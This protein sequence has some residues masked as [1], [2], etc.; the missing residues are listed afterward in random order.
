MSDIITRG[1]SIEGAV[2]AFASGFTVVFGNNDT[3]GFSIEGAVMA[4]ASGFS[5]V[6]GYGM[7]KEPTEPEE[8]PQAKIL[9]RAKGGAML[10]LGM[11]FWA[12]CIF[13]RFWAFDPTK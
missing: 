6:F 8:T 7:I 1:L 9:T 4:F 12:P 5:I 11:Y 13:R 10:M 2:M 3:L